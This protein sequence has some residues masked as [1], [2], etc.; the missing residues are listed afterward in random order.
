MD[1]EHKP[2][3]A[4]NQIRNSLALYSMR[5][6]PLGLEPDD[7]RDK[8]HTVLAGKGQIFLGVQAKLVATA[9][10]ERDGYRENLPSRVIA[11]QTAD[12]RKEALNWSANSWWKDRQTLLPEI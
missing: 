4:R 1:R 6:L 2:K 11:N 12:F 3:Q 8:R 9:G 5:C 10:L 7:N